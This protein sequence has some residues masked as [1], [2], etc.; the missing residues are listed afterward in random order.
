M[1]I[2]DKIRKTCRLV[3]VV[4]GGGAIGAGLAL[5]DGTLGGIG[6]WWLGAAPFIAGLADFCPLCIITKKCSIK[7]R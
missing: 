2:F 6:W 1:N 5:G 7:D 4:I 3:R